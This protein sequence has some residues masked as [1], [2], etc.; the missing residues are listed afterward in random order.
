MDYQKEFNKVLLSQP[1]CTLG[2]RGITDEF[3]KHC[4]QLL[5]KYKIVKIK[6]LKSVANKGNIREIANQIANSTSS[7]L[8][9]VRGKTFIISKKPI[10]RKR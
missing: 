6:A 1:H 8:L 10:E 4:V 9:D 2:K 7:H 5:K 3:I